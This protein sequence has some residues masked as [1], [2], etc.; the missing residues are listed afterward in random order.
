V[1]H[2]DTAYDA[3]LMT[4][5][6]RKEARARLAEEIDAVLASWKRHP[7]EVGAAQDAGEPLG[8]VSQE[9]DPGMLGRA[10]PGRP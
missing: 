7:D 3:L 5:V 2:L 4:G 6:P 1:R 8:T 9:P 10:A